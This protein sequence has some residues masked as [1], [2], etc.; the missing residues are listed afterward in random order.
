MV[1]VA[2]AWTTIPFRAIVGGG[3]VADGHALE[4]ELKKIAAAV[5][6]KPDAPQFKF[7]Y[8]EHKGM[9][10]AQRSAFHQV[11]RPQPYRRRLG[12]P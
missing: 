1:P 3:N 12:I 2:L 11:E 8:G 4:A 6:D 10:S 9:T 5:K 7:G